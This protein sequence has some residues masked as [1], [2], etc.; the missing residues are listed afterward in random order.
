MA[1][2][3]LRDIVFD[4]SIS[5]TGIFWKKAY[6]LWLRYI[7][8][9]SFISESVGVGKSWVSTEKNGT[10]GVFSGSNYE[11]VDLAGTFD[12]S[13]KY[14]YIVIN[15][16]TNYVNAGIYRIRT[17]VSTTKIIIDYRAGYGQYPLAATGLS[18]WICGPTYQTP[19][20]DDEYVRLGSN[21]TDGWALELRHF[22]GAG[23]LNVRVAPGGDWGKV[24][25]TEGGYSYYYP[26]LESSTEGR[27]VFTY[28]AE[29]DYDSHDWIHL[30]QC[31]P[32][33]QDTPRSTMN[34]V[35]IEHITP[36]ESTLAPYELITLRNALQA[37]GN[38]DCGGRQYESLRSLG[39]V[40]SDLAGGVV[41]LR[42]LDYTYSGRNNNFCV[43]AGHI[44]GREDNLRRDERREAMRG[45]YAII[46]EN[47]TTGNYQILGVVN[48]HWTVPVYPRAPI[49]LYGYGDFGEGDRAAHKL[50]MLNMD[51][52]G[53]LLLLVDDIAI[54]WCGLA[55]KG[56]GL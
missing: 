55:I 51:S 46:D 56:C 18:W 44:N 14:K 25:G 11:F 12:T 9:F 24:L 27:C 48:G 41:R 17:V 38:R 5:S 6:A 50:M 47:N 3:W 34:L 28:W 36:V 20:V 8:D 39:W 35:S 2:K 21:H 15:D 7:M 53:D 52:D 31:R 29:G 19:S 37:Y 49:S 40:W 32:I 54:P 4:T 10:G 13:D 1:S 22:N 42:L 43:S 26:G 45:S 23:R 30:F 16:N 33:Y